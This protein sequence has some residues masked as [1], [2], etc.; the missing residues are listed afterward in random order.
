MYVD[1]Y[2]YVDIFVQ[3]TLCIHLFS[4]LVNLCMCVFYV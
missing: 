2:A 4:Y 3:D 1:T